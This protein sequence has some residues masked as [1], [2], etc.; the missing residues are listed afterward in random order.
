MPAK[1]PQDSPQPLQIRSMGGNALDDLRAAETDCTP[2]E[3]LSER[4]RPTPKRPPFRPGFPGLVA[5]FL[6][7]A[8][9]SSRIVRVVTRLAPSVA[10]ALFSV[11]TTVL[12]AS[13]SESLWITTGMGR[14]VWP[15]P[16]VRVPSAS[17]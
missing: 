2:V 16:K 3:A 10:V 9:S 8:Y 5:C 17:V 1:S 12:F 15:A 11:T 4:S 14:D 7:V 13:T 6:A